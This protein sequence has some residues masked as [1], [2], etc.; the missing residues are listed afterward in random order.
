MNKD[1][2]MNEWTVVVENCTH[3]QVWSC[4]LLE[5]GCEILSRNPVTIEDIHPDE[6]STSWFNID[7]FRYIPD[8]P[9]LAGEYIIYST[10]GD[11]TSNS[12]IVKQEE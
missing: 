3:K 7:L 1:S 10:L 8:M 4:N 5:P 2:P 9:R 11:Y 12:I 6:V